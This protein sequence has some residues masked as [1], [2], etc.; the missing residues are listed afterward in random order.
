MYKHTHTQLE[1]EHNDED[2]YAAVA[3]DINDAEFT[4]NGAMGTWM[5]IVRA[6]NLV[7]LNITQLA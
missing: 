2:V 5:L 4:T 3:F 1:C 7:C 6:V